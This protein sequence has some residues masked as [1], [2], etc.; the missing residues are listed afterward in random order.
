[1]IISRL[2]GGRSAGCRQPLCRRGRRCSEREIC[3]G[4]AAAGGGRGRGQ[5][6]GG[7]RLGGGCSWAGAGVAATPPPAVDQLQGGPGHPLLGKQGAVINLASG[8][9]FLSVISSLFGMGA[10]KYLSVRIWHLAWFRLLIFA[11]SSST[12]LQAV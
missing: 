1:M 4:A 6:G 2:L 5:G 8:S 12:L 9:H 7:P 11:N 3:R 10:Q